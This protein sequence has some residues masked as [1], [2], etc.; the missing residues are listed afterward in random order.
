MYFAFKTR[1]QKAISET[2][3]LLIFHDPDVG[4]CVKACHVMPLHLSAA[5][6][7]TIQSKG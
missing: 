7:T 5:F 2:A 6:N 4:V 1:A 3:L